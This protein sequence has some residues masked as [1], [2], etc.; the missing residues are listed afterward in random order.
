MN[1]LVKFLI[2]HLSANVVTVLNSVLCEL[3]YMRIF[4]SAFKEIKYC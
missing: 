4:S 1:K 2:I 3:Q